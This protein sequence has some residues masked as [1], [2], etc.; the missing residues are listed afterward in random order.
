MFLGLECIIVFFSIGRRHTICA[1]V[2][3]VQMCA[4]PICM[5]IP[6][7]IFT[8]FMFPIENMP[9]V[10]QVISNIVP[11]RWYFLIIKAVMLKGLGFAYI[12]KE[13]L[14]LIVMTLRLE[15]RRVGNECVS[16]FRSWWSQSH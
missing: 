11:S 2:T 15:E 16:T 1:L 5:M 9:W 13:V 3:G 6:T 12:L 7:L 14:V 10:F 4:L 8:G